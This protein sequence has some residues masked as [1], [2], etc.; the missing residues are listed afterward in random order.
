MATTTATSPLVS[1]AQML[2]DAASATTNVSGGNETAAPVV[3]FDTCNNAYIEAGS[4]GKVPS[5]CDANS[6]FWRGYQ[7]CISCIRA[8]ANDA[9]MTIETYINPAF[10]QFI[11]Y[12]ASQPPQPSYPSTF[13][14]TRTVV[15]FVDVTALNG[16]VQPGVLRTRTVT[17]L[18]AEVTGLLT[19]T[20][21]GLSP[22]RT[23]PT[24]TMPAGTSAT[25]A[26][27]PFPERDK[28]WIAGPVIGAV[29][30]ILLALAGLWFLRRRSRRAFD[31]SAA[32]A[33]GYGKEEFTKAKL[34]SD[35]IPRGYVAELEDSWPKA[36]PEM[37]ANEIP[38]QELPVSDGRHVEG[39]TGRNS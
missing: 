8:E 21:N 25:V 37:S 17:E 22:Q 33:N 15:Q 35:C 13:M 14:T 2:S 27:E 16:K 29:T 11:D 12:C 9:E 31:W 5:M 32:K 28:A 1:P 19:A 20:S 30:A 23:S 18:K 38:S 39:V 34:H 3:C 6:D 26:Q 36:M 7:E 4:V 24:A 10:K